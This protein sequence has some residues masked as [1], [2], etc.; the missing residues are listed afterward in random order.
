MLE[1][2]DQNVNQVLLSV[3]VLPELKS[4]ESNDIAQYHFKSK[5]IKVYSR[6]EHNCIPGK[7]HIQ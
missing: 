7:Y 3:C 1:V 5:R 6:G 2:Q 4:R